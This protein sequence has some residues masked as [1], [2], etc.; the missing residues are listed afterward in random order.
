MLLLGK[1][2]LT[3]ELVRIKQ[4]LQELKFCGIQQMIINCDNQRALYIASYPVFHYKDK[5]QIYSH[6]V[7][8]KL[9]SKDLIIMFVNSNEQLAD[10]PTKSLREPRI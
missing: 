2:L 10:V 4:C 5:T 1:A 9:L 7:T 8:E 3:C 6:F